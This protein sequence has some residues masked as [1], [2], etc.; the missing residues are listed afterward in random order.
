MSFWMQISSWIN[1]GV[2]IILL[3]G[4]GIAVWMF[5]QYFS[6]KGNYPVTEDLIGQIGIVKKDCSPHQRGKV[7]VDGAYWDAICEHGSVRIGDDIKVIRVEEKF[8]VV[9]K[10][11][12]IGN[13]DNKS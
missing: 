4:L 3:A 6:I 7:Y 5:M 11:D 8:L 2:P 1:Y 10:V 13:Q 12:L 9:A